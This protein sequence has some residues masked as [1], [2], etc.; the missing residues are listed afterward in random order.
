MYKPNSISEL[1]QKSYQL[2]IEKKRQNYTLACA[3]DDWHQG[4]TLLY[5]KEKCRVYEGDSKN[6]RLCSP[7]GAVSQ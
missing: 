3:I 5:D 4:H 1:F 6:I 7:E 2:V